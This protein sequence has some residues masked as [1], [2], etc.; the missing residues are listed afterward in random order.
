MTTFA[1]TLL[2]RDHAP[3]D[4]GATP[5]RFV[6][7]PSDTR[8]LV[9]R[10]I[11]RDRR[12]ID[13]LVAMLA[14]VV[15]VRVARTLERSASR[16][17]RRDLRQDVEDLVQEVFSALFANGGR[18]LQAWDPE[19][20]ASLINFV[21][22][23]AEHHV[24]SILRSSRRQPWGREIASSDT[25]EIAS[26]VSPEGPVASRQLF[27]RVLDR[28]RGEVSPRGLELFYALVV[29]EE[30]LDAVCARFAMNPDSVYAWRSR[31]L[32]RARAIL[33]ELNEPPSSR[34]AREISSR[35]ARPGSEADTDGHQEPSR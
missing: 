24:A 4:D 9:A 21:G 27:A 18:V 35:A 32:K 22:L 17:G 30:P 29:H 34:R 13:A 12:A 31:L 23:V 28:L 25:L 1:P 11:A 8:E 6:S 3:V 26:P 20:G 33:V 19:R 16:C 5:A 15:H 2:A 14:P 10:A 7:P